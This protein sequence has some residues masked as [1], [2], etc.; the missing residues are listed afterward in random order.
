MISVSFGHVESYMLTVNIYNKHLFILI[1]TK[2]LSQIMLYPTTYFVCEGVRVS[3]RVIQKNK[4]F[5]FSSG[6]PL[7]LFLYVK[8]YSCQVLK[9]LKKN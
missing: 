3:S 5:Y 1:F 7:I 4:S 2:T 9:I 6:Q 8:E